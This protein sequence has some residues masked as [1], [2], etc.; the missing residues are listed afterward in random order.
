LEPLFGSVWLC[1]VDC[2]L[3]KQLGAAAAVWK[4]FVLSGGGFAML[5]GDLLTLRQHQLPVKILVFKNDSLPFVEL[6]LKAAGIVDFGTSLHNP[7]FAK[8]AQEPDSWA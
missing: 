7:D 3:S 2:S 4:A 5:M 8:I 6:E 1:R